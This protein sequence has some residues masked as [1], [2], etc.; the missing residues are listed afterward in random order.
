MQTFS[1]HLLL[2][3]FI[4]SAIAIWFAGVSL[5]KATDTIDMRFKLGEALGGLILLGIATSLPEI[6]IVVSAALNGHYQVIIGNLIGGIA[7]QTLVLAIFDAFVKGKKP[8][9]YLAGSPIL[10]LEGLFVISITVLAI[11][12]FKIGHSFNIYG[13]GGISI[14]LVAG[15]LLGLY[16]IDKVRLKPSLNATAPEAD[17]GRKHHERRAIEH[18]FFKGRSNLHVIWIFSVA[19]LAILI[20]GVFLERSGTA[21]A[22]QL[23][24]SSGI[25]A[26]TFMAFVAALPEIST[27]IESIIIGDNL[28]AISDIFGG[29]AFM[30]SLFLLGDIIAGKSILAHATTQDY[31]FAVLGIVLTGIYVLSYLFKP[32]R[33]FLRLGLDSILVIVIY[34]AG[35]TLLFMR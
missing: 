33:R 26:A 5:T 10:I 13:V 2:I 6:A 14:L 28:L 15:W 20:A 18:R 21:L 9:S 22:G 27:G 24:I 16:I 19:A 11:L 4:A 23:G 30:P 1:T 8:L 25:F 35:L 34:G 7:L 32:Q 29:N 3:I 12:G 17:P 31:W